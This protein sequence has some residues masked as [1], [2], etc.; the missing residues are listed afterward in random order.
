MSVTLL[1][2]EGKNFLTQPLW[3]LLGLD[4]HKGRRG[5]PSNAK[6]LQVSFSLQTP[7]IENGTVLHCTIG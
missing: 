2:P 3:I 1:V 4:M 7:E 6:T 5:F